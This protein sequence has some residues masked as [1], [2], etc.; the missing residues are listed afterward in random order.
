MVGLKLKQ[1]AR[2][3]SVPTRGHGQLFISNIR[4]F[5]KLV[6]IGIASLGIGRLLRQ[7]MVHRNP[8]LHRI[9]LLINIIGVVS[10]FSG[11]NEIVYDEIVHPPRTNLMRCFILHLDFA[12]CMQ[13]YRLNPIQLNE[14]YM[15]LRFPQDI[16]L[17]HRRINS[18]WAFLVFMYRQCSGCTFSILVNKWG[19]DPTVLCRTYNYVLEFIYENWASLFLHGNDEI[20]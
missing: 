10:V 8:Q 17:F 11:I 18:Q 1:P 2:R 19:S 14:L 12:D 16:P 20:L 7:H 15:S 4:E 6:K 5:K 3:L 13:C 9:V